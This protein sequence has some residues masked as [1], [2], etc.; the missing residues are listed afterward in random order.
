EEVA[1]VRAI[2]PDL[3]AADPDA[4]ADSAT[5]GR[6]VCS[7][8]SLRLAVFLRRRRLRCCAEL[9]AGA[10]GYPDSAGPGIRVRFE[11]LDLCGRDCSTKQLE[12]LVTS[13]LAAS[14]ESLAGAP[15]LMQLVQVLVD[16]LDELESDCASP[17]GESQ[18]VSPAAVDAQGVPAS[19]DCSQDATAWR[20]VL[21]HLEHMR[22]RKI[23]L[24]HLRSWTDSLGAGFSCRVLLHDCRSSIAAHLLL[25][26]PAARVA[27]FLRRL[28]TERV[29]I[30]SR[31]RPCRERLMSVLLDESAGRRDASDASGF[32]T[33]TCCQPDSVRV[34]MTQHGCADWLPSVLH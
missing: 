13:S 1:A 30:D 2:F 28:R 20:C 32:K 27:E 18:T 24:S 16:L 25:A 34:E 5:A 9:D 15:A 11:S 4:D 12:E 17:S 10:P 21:V 7:S 8:R 3:L 31:G 33:L 22:S 14:A 6:A 26:G 19:A 23:Y 29:D